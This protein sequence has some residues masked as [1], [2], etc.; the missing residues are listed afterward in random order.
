[1]AGYHWD[2]K[3]TVLVCFVSQASMAL[4]LDFHGLKGLSRQPPGGCLRRVTPQRV[5]QH[6]VV[7][8]NFGKSRSM[9]ALASEFLMGFQ[10]T[11]PVVAVAVP[12]LLHGHTTSLCVLFRG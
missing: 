4:L 2:D 6:A 10:V 12:A 3:R 9:V 8:W 5:R 7:G 1:M 11:S